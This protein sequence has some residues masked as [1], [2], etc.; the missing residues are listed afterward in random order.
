MAASKLRV[1]ISFYIVQE[2]RLTV[3]V[4]KLHLMYM[5]LT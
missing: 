2:F 3:L 1:S 4:L 5:R